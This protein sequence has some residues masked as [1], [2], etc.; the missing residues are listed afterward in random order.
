MIEYKLG[1]E[2]RAA[3]RLSRIVNPGLSSLTLKVLALIVPHS[4]QLQDIIKEVEECEEIQLLLDKIKKR[5]EVKKG[6]AI[7]ENLLLYKKRLVISLV[8][9]FIPGNSVGVS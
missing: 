5:I 9:K 1:I 6:Y 4:L 8:S 2:N 3:D 7:V